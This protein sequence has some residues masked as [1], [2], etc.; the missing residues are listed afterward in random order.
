LETTSLGMH[1]AC[2]HPRGI[3]L[4]DINA[5]SNEVMPR[6]RFTHGCHPSRGH[7]I[8]GVTERYSFTGSGFYTNIQGKR[9][10]LTGRGVHDAE[11]REACFIP[12]GNLP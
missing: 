2:G 11:V 3:E 8:I 12:L 1:A 7:L 4:F 5:T 10:A 9:L 6:E